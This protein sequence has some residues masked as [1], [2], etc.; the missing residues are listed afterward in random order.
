MHALTTFVGDHGIYAVFLLMAADAL[1][2]VGGEAIMIYA[3]A[4]P[5]GVVG[6][7]APELLGSTLH[8]DVKGYAVMALA[9]TLGYLVGSWLGW[10]IGRRGGRSLI[11]RHG[12]WLHLGP[13]RLTKAERWF[14]RHGA[15]AV[16]VGRL[17]PLV[18]SFIS[19][20]AGVMRVPIGSYSAL[21]LLGSAIWCFA[22]GGIGW[23]MGGNY[24]QADSVVKILEVAG[25]V[26]L[27]LGVAALLVRRRQANAIG[28]ED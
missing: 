6:G 4:L 2:P 24:Q 22:F 1:L 13:E 8:A 3:G 26:V 17:T 21:T 12:C 28:L 9:G 14:K 25:A 15:A 11:E 5:T 7:H 23:A 18:R 10:G 16:F 20:T 27:V 19:V